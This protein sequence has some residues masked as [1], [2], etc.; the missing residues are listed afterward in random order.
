[1]QENQFFQWA[2]WAT[3]YSLLA[4]ITMS[5]CRGTECSEDFLVL[6]VSVCFT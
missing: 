6:R 1:M 4:G 2:T 5:V 3:Y